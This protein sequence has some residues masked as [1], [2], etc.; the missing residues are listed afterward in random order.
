M[1]RVF[2]RIKYAVLLRWWAVL[3]P[4][5]LKQLKVVLGDR[6]VFYGWPIIAVA[7]GSQV[8]IGSRVVLCSDSH[9][10]ALGVASPVILRTLSAGAEID[11][12]PDSGLSGTTICAQKSV[13]IGAE[14]MFGANVK[15]FDTDFH[16]LSAEGRRYS[17]GESEIASAAVVIGRNVFVGAGSIIMK[18]VNIGDNVVIG[19][20]SVVTK[21]VPAGRIVAGN[22]ARNIRYISCL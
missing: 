13:R 14:C 8:R 20:G 15:I 22:P 12:G 1:I 19:A 10:T 6:V 4:L 2:F 3:V 16:G 17:T 11:I 18:G 7:K 5:Y 9:F 21:D